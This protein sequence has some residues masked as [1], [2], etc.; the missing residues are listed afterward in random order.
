MHNSNALPWW[1]V[2]CTTAT[3]CLGDT[4]HANLALGDTWHPFLPR[5]FHLPL[6][7]RHLHPLPTPPHPAVPGE[8]ADAEQQ[9]AFVRDMGTTPEPEMMFSEALI[10]WR[11]GGDATAAI[12]HLDRALETHMSNIENL[13]HD[14]D[15]FGKLNPDFLLE[16]SREYLRHCTG[17]QSGGSVDEQS[18]TALLLSKA[19]KLLQLV[20]K[21]VG[22]HAS[23][24][25]HPP[26]SSS[27][28]GR[29]SL[30]PPLGGPSLPPLLAQAAAYLPVDTWPPPR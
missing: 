16:I 18:P 20:A 30:R 15:Y 1:H 5:L 23:S 4:W 29:R 2:A 28:P 3:C 6:P 10:A 19:S 27:R 25:P 14:A 13:P 17:E 7:A 21:Q 26:K 12:S 9:I 22:A 11:R 24:P 8:L